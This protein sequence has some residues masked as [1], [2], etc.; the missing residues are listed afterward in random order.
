[1]DFLTVSLFAFGFALAGYM[2]VTGIVRMSTEDIKK[3]ME[4]ESASSFSWIYTITLQDEI[5]RLR[6]YKTLSFHIV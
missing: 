3:R 4:N 6:K 2:I 1:M 5:R